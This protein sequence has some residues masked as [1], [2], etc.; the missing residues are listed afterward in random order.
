MGIAASKAGENPIQRTPVLNVRVPGLMPDSGAA[1]V[2]Y[3]FGYHSHRLIAVNILWSKATDPDITPQQLYRNGQILRQ[4][5][6]AEGFP[7]QRSTDNVALPDGVLL[8]RASD[9]AGNVVLLA[10]SGAIVKD[11]NSP[12]QT[13]LKPATL[14]LAY[15]A[16]PQHPD[17]YHLNKGSF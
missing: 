6:A 12:H 15:A 11:K 4:Y 16:D 10:L 5:F 17:V 2:A 1:N 3:V 9:T 14:S 7:P 8:F 13:T